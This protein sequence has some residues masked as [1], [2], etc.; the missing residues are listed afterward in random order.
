VLAPSVQASNGD[1]EGGA[2]VV[3]I[4]AL[5]AGIPV[6]G[7]RHCD[8]PNIVQHGRTGLLSEERDIEDLARNLS[9]LAADPQAR[10]EMGREAVAY[11][12]AEHDIKRQVRKITAVYREAAC[13]SRSSSS[14]P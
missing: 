6:V 3:V 10:A 1:N 7:S 11:A 9:R 12:H 5:A 4:E 8:I 2:P 14:L 13:G